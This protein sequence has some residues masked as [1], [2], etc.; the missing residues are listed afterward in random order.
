[1]HIEVPSLE[2]LTLSYN[3]NFLEY[4]QNA[5]LYHFTLNTLSNCAKKAGFKL[6]RGN[7]M[8]QALF[9]IGNSDKS[10]SNQYDTTLK[11]LNSLEI[12]QSKPISL[13]KIK[14]KIFSII[15]KILRLTRT[16]HIG[17]ILYYKYTK[18]TDK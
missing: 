7:Q 13:M 15:F 1:M 18:S 2:H 3:Q 16:L 9:K 6:I 14:G 8:T 12:L 5:H 4:L 11:F 17:Q 10:Y